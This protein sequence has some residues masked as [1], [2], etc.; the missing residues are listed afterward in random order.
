[1][2]EIRKSN[3][4][5]IQENYNQQ[6]LDE[7]SSSFICS[8]DNKFFYFSRILG[9]WPL[10][11]LWSNINIPT[12]HVWDSKS[13]FIKSQKSSNQMAPSSSEDKLSYSLL[14]NKKVTSSYSA[15]IWQME[16]SCG[17][18]RSVGTEHLETIQNILTDCINNFW[19]KPLCFLP[20][21]YR[22]QSTRNVQTFW[23]QNFTKGHW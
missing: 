4:Q 11:K 15:R 16:P 18:L 2:F 23:L 17:T 6:S 14:S 20:L 21:Q 9:F 1:M 12:N 19:S 13:S 3:I 10:S 22:Y 8:N 5:K 7:E